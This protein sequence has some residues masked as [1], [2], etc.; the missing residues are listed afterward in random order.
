MLLKELQR[1]LRV[2]ELDKLEFKS[3]NVIYNHRRIMFFA[4][5]LRKT[6]VDR[7]TINFMYNRT[8]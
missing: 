4:P 5:M 7:I 8:Y 3:G 6:I 2:P 1:M